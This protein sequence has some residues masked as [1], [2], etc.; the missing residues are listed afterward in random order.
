MRTSR[1]RPSDGCETTLA[2]RLRLPVRGYSEG[3]AGLFWRNF[4][5]P[6]FTRMFGERLSALP[7]SA[8][9]DLGGGIVLVQPYELPTQAGTPEGLASER[10]LIAQ[11]GEECFYDHECHLKPSRRPVLPHVLHKPEPTDR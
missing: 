3:L 4:F 6:P 8:K 9:Q 7:S 10:Q 1:V 5:G 11:L 2:K